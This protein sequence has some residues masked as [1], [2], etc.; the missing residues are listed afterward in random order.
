MVFRR[1]NTVGKSEYTMYLNDMA[2]KNIGLNRIYSYR[3]FADELQS[4]NRASTIMLP[5]L[6]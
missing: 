1:V 2:F 6:L 3:S 4:R 5:F